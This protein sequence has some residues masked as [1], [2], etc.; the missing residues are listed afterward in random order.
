MSFVI[1][2]NVLSRAIY[3]KIDAELR[4][5]PD[6]A[7]N[8]EAFYRQLVA[9]YNE[10]GYVPE[11]SLEK[12]NDEKKRSEPTIN[13]PTIIECV[14]CTDCELTAQ[15]DCPE[16]GITEPIYCA[17]HVIAH[18]EDEHGVRMRVSLPVTKPTTTDDTAN[19]PRVL[20]AEECDE[21]ARRASTSTVQM[22]DT[23]AG[24]NSAVWRC[25]RCEFRWAS[26]SK[27]P[28]PMCVA[29]PMCV[30]SASVARLLAT[31]DAL[32]AER[33]L[34][35]ECLETIAS[36]SLRWIEDAPLPDSSLMWRGMTQQTAQEA[37]VV[38]DR[39]K[40]GQE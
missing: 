2:P 22:V 23:I 35:V 21:I 20:S 17:R 39:L 4:R 19:L 6:A 15:F 14:S 28:C 26:P 18:R 30:G 1:V 31:I 38:L 7:P 27:C 24:T 12:L 11:F 10:H 8:R 5:V 3:A 40:R 33:E 36:R 32:R 13:R 37:T 34:A 29:C 25:E 16:C 9:F